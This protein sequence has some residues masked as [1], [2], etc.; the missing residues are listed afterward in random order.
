[1]VRVLLV[2]CLPLTSRVP[3]ILNAGLALR[4]NCR[5]R[6]ALRE[7]H[8]RS[9]FFQLSFC[10]TSWDSLLRLCLSDDPMQSYLP[11]VNKTHY[12]FTGVREQPATGGGIWSVPRSI[13][14][15]QNRQMQDSKLYILLHPDNDRSCDWKLL[16]KYVTRANNNPVSG[17]IDDSLSLQDTRTRGS[18]V[19]DGVVRQT[20]SCQ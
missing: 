6:R 11:K 2:K 4:N 16:T 19:V 9:I 18:Y 17:K 5:R 20:P 15:W 1:M 13:S 7:L 12:A 14:I 3:P 10:D 8:Q